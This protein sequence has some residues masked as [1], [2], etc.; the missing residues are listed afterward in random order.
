VLLPKRYLRL[1][2]I[3][4]PVSGI[5]ALGLLISEGSPAFAESHFSCGRDL[6]ACKRC[7]PMI[8]RFYGIRY[9]AVFLYHLQALYRLRRS[10]YIIV[11]FMQMYLEAPLLLAR[12][13]E[14]RLLVR[15]AIRGG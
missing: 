14:G 13:F 15:Y 9:I 11:H 2:Q 5:D 12:G 6:M 7:R 3:D 4:L 8:L 1:S 10:K